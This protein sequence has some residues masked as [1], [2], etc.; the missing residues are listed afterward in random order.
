MM[1]LI[2]DDVEVKTTY[3]SFESTKSS[4]PF[5]VTVCAP[6]KTISSREGL[7]TVK[8]FSAYTFFTF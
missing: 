6:Q 7:V 5:P 8:T 1:S 4:K 2:I 3:I